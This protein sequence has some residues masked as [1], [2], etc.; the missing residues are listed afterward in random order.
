VR[1]LYSNAAKQHVKLLLSGDEVL[2]GD[3]A[4]AEAT[5]W[6]AAREIGVAKIRTSD[7]VVHKSNVEWLEL[8]AGSSLTGLSKCA[9]GACDVIT[10]GDVMVGLNVKD[11][12]LFDEILAGDVAVELHPTGVVLS[13]RVTQA[14]TVKSEVESRSVPSLRADVTSGSLVKAA[15]RRNGGV[16]L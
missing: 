6:H 5:A 4:D 3:L 10:A 2:T 16:P 1:V 12:S 7:G 8:A 13:T 9:G 11:R 14:K 15:L